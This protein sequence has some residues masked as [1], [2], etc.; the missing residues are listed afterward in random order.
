MY[1]RLGTKTAFLVTEQDVAMKC[2]RRTAIL[3]NI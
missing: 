3:S 2:Y 1:L